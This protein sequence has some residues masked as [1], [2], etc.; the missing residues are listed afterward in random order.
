MLRSST[1]RLSKR[2]EPAKVIAVGFSIGTGIAAQ[3]CR[4]AESR[5]T[6]PC[7]AVRFAEGASPSRCFRGCRSDLSSGTRSTLQRTACANI[8]FRWRSSRLN[9][10]RSCPAKRTRGARGSACGRLF[11]TA[12]LPRRTQRH[13]YPVGLPRRDA[14]SALDLSSRAVTYGSSMPLAR[15]GAAIHILEIKGP[16]GRRDTLTH[17]QC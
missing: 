16:I 14:L 5:R 9:G 6:D 1:M 10:T 8:M 11:S 13:L 7:D 17:P 12:R 4:H 2:L 3:L 15:P